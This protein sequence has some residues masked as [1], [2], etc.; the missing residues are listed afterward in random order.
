MRQIR[1]L[2]TPRG[3]FR[4]EVARQQIRRIGLQQQTFRR[5]RRQQ[6]AQLQSPPLIAYPTGNTDKQAQIQAFLHL[7]AAAGKAVQHRARELLKPGFKQ[8]QKPIVGVA[9]VQKHRH[10]QLSGQR[11]LGAERYLL[12]VRRGKIPVK[13]QTALAYRHHL[14]LAGE[15]INRLGD[16]WRPAATVM[17][18]N[19]RRGPAAGIA[20]RQFLRQLALRQICA[21]QQHAVNPRRQ[22]ARHY[23]IMIAGKLRTGQINADI[24][25]D[26]SHMPTALTGGWRYYSSLCSAASASA[27]ASSS[28]VRRFPV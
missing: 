20:A 17:G 18:M 2:V 23:L 5:D 12:L 3:R 28:R 26:R 4:L 13:I 27:A 15:G 7:A 24:K 14:R 16:R 8:R 25:H 11:Q 9:A 10:R 22:G 19:P 21:G 6:L 1:G